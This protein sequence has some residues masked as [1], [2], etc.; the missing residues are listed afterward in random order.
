[1]NDKPS[2]DGAQNDARLEAIRAALAE[3]RVEYAEVLPGLV[4]EL[5]AATEEACAPVEGADLKKLTTLA[6]RMHGAAGSYGFGGVSAVAGKMEHLLHDHEAN[7][8][9]IEALR[10]GL[11]AGA[12]EIQ[13]TARREIAELVAL[14]Q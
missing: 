7:G 11:R 1:M 13:E 6:H 8:L 10:A 14:P 12:I 3:L 5:V 4:S 9:P 2:R